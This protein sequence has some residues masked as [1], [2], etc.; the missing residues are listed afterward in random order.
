MD[1]Q[2]ATSVFM[3]LEEPRLHDD[4]NSREWN[5]P[6]FDVRLDAGTDRE[7]NRTYRVRV[8]PGDAQLENMEDMWRFVLD[9]AKRFELAVDIQNHGMELA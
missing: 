9:E 8:I 6:I 5:P 3:S 2:T 1:R 7:G 4:A